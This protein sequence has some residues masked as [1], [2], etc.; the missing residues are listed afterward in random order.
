MNAPESDSTILCWRGTTVRRF[1]SSTCAVYLIH[2]EKAYK[3]A[4]HYLGYAQDVDVR[5]QRHRAGNGAR[6]MEVIVDAG[7]SWEVSR[8]W[9]CEDEHQARLLERRLKHW[10]G[11]GQFCPLCQGKPLDP[12]TSLRQGHWPMALHTSVGKRQPC[13]RRPLFIHREML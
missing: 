3:H 2:F 4:R 9:P 1:P 13:E 6:L 8:L 12:Y 11:S 10:H 7:I 5:L